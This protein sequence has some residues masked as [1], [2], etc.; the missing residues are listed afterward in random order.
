MTRYLTLAFLLL[1]LT[2]SA[3][4]HKKSK[5][6]PEEYTTAIVDS[7]IQSG[8]YE[9]AIWYNINLFGRD[10]AAAKEKIVLLKDKVPNLPLEIYTVFSKFAPFDPGI[11][12]EAGSG[13]MSLNV[14][15]MKRR[16]RWGDALIRVV[17]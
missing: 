3:G 1:S 10:S 6:Y 5:A 14:D 15:E 8:N 17:R 11:N 9:L 12:S 2:A 7:A 4:K 16:G 13:G